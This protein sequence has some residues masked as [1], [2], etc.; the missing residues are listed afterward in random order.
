MPLVSLPC[1]GHL[2]R[3]EY[4][5]ECHELVETIEKETRERHQSEGT[6]VL[7]TPAILSTH[8]QKRP[9]KLKKSPAPLA[10]AKDPENAPR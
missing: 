7:G 9:H 10:H 5:K 6:G 1:W 8:P 2:S 3:E 4:A